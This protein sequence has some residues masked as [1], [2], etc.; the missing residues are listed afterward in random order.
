MPGPG[1]S[2]P[3]FGEICARSRMEGAMSSTVIPCLRYRDARRMLVWLRAVFGFAPQA[4][5]EDGA[6][7]IAHAQLTLGA[8]MIMLGSARDVAFGRLQAKPTA[9]GGTTRSPYHVVPD[10]DEVYRRA[11]AAGAGIVIE[12]KDED[13]GGRGFSCRDPEGHLWNIGTCDPWRTK[14]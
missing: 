2:A 3:V 10:A 7:G 9:L 1:G 12:I 8:G 5:Y 14:S 13:Y 6:G 4:V 11:N